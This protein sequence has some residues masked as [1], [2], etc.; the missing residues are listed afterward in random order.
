VKQRVIIAVTCL[1]VVASFFS[2][3]ASEKDNGIDSEGSLTLFDAGP[4]TLDPAIARSGRS[5]NFIVEI[6]SGLV[7]FDP[8]LNLIPDVAERWDI[9]NEGRT[10]TFYIREGVKFHNGKEVTASDFKYSLERACDPSTGSLT[11]ATYL[12]DIV[13]VNEKISGESHDIT[14]VKLLDRYILEITI[15]DA[16]QY[17]L[18]KLAHPVAFVVERLNVESGDEWWKKPDGTGPFM[19][20]EWEIDEL[21]VLDRNEEYYLDPPHINHVVYRLLAG[22]PMTMYENGEIDVADVY[23]SD[24][25]RVQDPNNPLNQELTV[26]PSLSLFYIGFNVTEPPFDDVKVRQAFCHAIDRDKIVKLVLKDQVTIANGILPPGM[27]GYNP[28][29]EGLAF[30]VER[31]RRLIS[32]SSY[33]DVENIGTVVFTTSGRGIASNLEAALVDMWRR[34]L[35]IEVMIRQLEPEAYPYLI[36]QEKDGMFSLGWG[37]DYPDPQNFLDVLYHSESNHNIGEYDNATMDM[38]IEQARTEKGVNEREDYYQEAEQLIIDDAACL[39]LYF[40]V[41]YKLVKPYVENL[42]HTPMWIPR[43]KYV[44]VEEH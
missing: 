42:P 2:C 24:I 32:E 13:G 5:L 20:S 21:L 1:I 10:Y 3:S 8:D 27:P 7:S 43:L 33:S 22:I 29:V 19:L 15:D 16:K 12:G 9:S 31:A 23:L 44:T 4:L 6:F 35:G 34:N 17:F 11:A 41:T 30:D 14:G 18:S 26:T 39:P 37:A 28:D 25:E 38:L 40:D 36:A